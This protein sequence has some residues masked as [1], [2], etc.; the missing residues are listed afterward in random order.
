MSDTRL[1]LVVLM[2][3]Q[4]GQLCLFIWLHALSKDLSHLSRLADSQYQYTNALA[5]FIDPRRRTQ[6]RTPA[7]VVS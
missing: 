2:L 3:L 4:I 1:V 7:Q 5:D 6:S